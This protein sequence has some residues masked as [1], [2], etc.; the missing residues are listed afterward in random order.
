[1]KQSM[2]T[3]RVF[4]RFLRNIEEAG[5]EGTSRTSLYS[6]LGTETWRFD[7]IVDIL[8]K[9]GELQKHEIPTKNAFNRGRGPI[10]YVYTADP[11][12][13]PVQFPTDEEIEAVKE[14]WEASSSTTMEMGECVYC[15]KSFKRR[16]RGPRRKFCSATCR[17]TAEYSVQRQTKS[18]VNTENTFDRIASVF[19][20]VVAD[21]I[22]RG[23][24]VYVSVP[25]N[26][27]HVLIMRDG[28]ATLIDYQI[29]NDKGEFPGLTDQPTAKVFRSGRI[30]YVNIDLDKRP[31]VLDM[32]QPVLLNNQVVD[33][34]DDE[35]G[36]GEEIL[37]EPLP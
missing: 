26:T 16:A 11:K 5:A 4:E 37:Y 7:L 10:W 12:L 25:H 29:E 32:K 34:N 13:P 27:N 28:Q 22:R 3:R 8:E 33:Y 21:L 9:R 30:E 31:A 14:A 20:L 6:R 35:D 18:I 17:S 24:N 1:M 19:Y 23:L 2:K 36:V 15:G